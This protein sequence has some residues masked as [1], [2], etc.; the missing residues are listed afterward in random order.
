MKV[1]FYSTYYDVVDDDVLRFQRMHSVGM[2][3]HTHVLIE[4]GHLH[5]GWRTL[6]SFVA[7]WEWDMDH[8]TLGL[9]W[10]WMRFDA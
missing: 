3:G 9:G 7:K 8:S 2:T 1:G 4:F 6:V 5:S 10:E